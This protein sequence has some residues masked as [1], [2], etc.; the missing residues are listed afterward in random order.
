ME[1][2]EKVFLE[3]QSITYRYLKVT[4]IGLSTIIWSKWDDKIVFYIFGLIFQLNPFDL[5]L[6]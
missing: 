6:T 3:N 1:V 5:V 4:F 2:L